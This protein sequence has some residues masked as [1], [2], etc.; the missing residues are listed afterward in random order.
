MAVIELVVGRQPVFDSELE[1]VGYELIV[2]RDECDAAVRDPSE[3]VG[4]TASVLYDAVSIGVSRLVGDRFLFCDADRAV[5]VGSVPLVVPPEQTVLEVDAALADDEAVVSGCAALAEAGFTIALDRVDDLGRCAPLLGTAG[6][7][8]VDHESLAPERVAKLVREVK[9][10]GLLALALGV[11]APS[12]LERFR[13]LGFDYF[14]GDLLSAP[15][16]VPGRTLDASSVARLRQA[17]RLV[18]QQCSAAELEE[19][20]R[21]EPA[22]AY[23]LLQ[24][25]GVGADNGFRR[26]VRSIREALVLLGW[27]HLQS[28]IGF[29]LETRRGSTSDDEAITTLTRARMCELL[30]QRSYP[31]LADVAFAAGMLS[32]FD[33]LLDMPLD[34]VL[35]TLPLDE[36]LRDAVARADT[37]VGRIVAD[38]VDCQLG[39][40]QDA[41]RSG[42]S[43]VT[44]SGA[45]IA[46]LR[47][48]IEASKHAVT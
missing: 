48:A 40:S 24:I 18:S 42:F 31:A 23:Q 28:W 1:V 9:S 33:M 36:V 32:A 6:I 8:K 44:L 46:A 35:A 25:A 2:R 47:W 38:V 21:A 20:V 7:V 45:A 43:E 11:S 29:L 12:Q 17:A 27:R 34:E 13:E 37:P 41:T 4:A 15:Q 26:P 5:L 3:E 16:V 22:L 10:R 39:R 30:A 19:V 14:Q